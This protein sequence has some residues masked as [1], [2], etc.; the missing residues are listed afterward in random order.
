M[1]LPLGQD[2]RERQRLINE[3]ADSPGSSLGRESN[4][5]TSTAPAAPE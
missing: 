2:S 4:A 3:N 1:R 5:S